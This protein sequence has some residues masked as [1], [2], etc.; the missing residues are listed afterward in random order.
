[1]KRLETMVAA[2]VVVAALGG[3]AA[4]DEQRTKAEGAGIGAVVFEGA[5]PAVSA[6][7]RG[8]ATGAM[9]TVIAETM[10]PEAFARGGSSSGLAA[11]AGFLVT[12][13]VGA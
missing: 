9:I 3:C 2:A 13:L 11:L 4:T 12:V 8:V 7:I 10:L 1:M 5:S 6:G